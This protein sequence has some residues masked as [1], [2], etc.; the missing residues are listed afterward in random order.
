MNLQQRPEENNISFISL[1]ISGYDIQITVSTNLH[2]YIYVVVLHKISWLQF[3]ICNLLY[4]LLACIRESV[5][6]QSFMTF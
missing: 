5:L 4:V 1:N 6:S 2:F 3:F